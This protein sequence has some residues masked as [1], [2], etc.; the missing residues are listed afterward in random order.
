MNRDLSFLLSLS[1]LLFAITIIIFAIL[2]GVF[3]KHILCL[4]DP[5]NIA[6]LLQTFNL[7]GFLGSLIFLKKMPSIA[8]DIGMGLF[9]W[10]SIFIIVFI[11]FKR[12]KYTVEIAASKSEQTFFI[13]WSVFLLFLNLS[14]NYIYFGHI[15]LIEGTQTRAIMGQ[16]PLPSLIFLA[17]ILGSYCLYV[18]VVSRFTSVKKLAKIGVILQIIV[19]ILGGSKSILLVLLLMWGFC[20]YC[21]KAL[22]NNTRNISPVINSKSRRTSIITILVVLTFVLGTPLLVSF[23]NHGSGIKEGLLLTIQRLLMGFDALI[24]V[25]LNDLNVYSV[26]HQSIFDF[27]FYAPIKKLLYTPEF[28][29]AGELLIYELTSNKEFALGGLNPN[30]N[31]ILEFMFTTSKATYLFFTAIT[32]FV[33]YLFITYIYNKKNKGILSGILL[34]FIC[35]SPFAL[36]QDGSYFFSQLILLAIFYITV[37]ALYTAL[38]IASKKNPGYSNEQ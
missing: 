20:H 19:L 15:P 36:L 12:K 3:R 38:I 5:I 23:L 24:F 31:L 34:V 1:L 27:W 4:T 17:N 25:V 37:K 11:L 2:R 14:I 26:T 22:M 29:S 8:V 21:K 18:A 7:V 6:L 28:R 30:S 13:F 16:S 32:G 9:V 33:Y 35:F 10:Y